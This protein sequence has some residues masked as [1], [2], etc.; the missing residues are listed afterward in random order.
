MGVCSRI[1]VLLRVFGAI[2]FKDLGVF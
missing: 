1:G 2:I